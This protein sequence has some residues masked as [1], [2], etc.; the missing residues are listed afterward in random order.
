MTSI[1]TTFANLIKAWGNLP[2][3]Y[4]NYVSLFVITF[5]IGVISIF[6]PALQVLYGIVFFAISVVTVFNP[7]DFTETPEHSTVNHFDHASRYNWWTYSMA[8]FVAVATLLFVFLPINQS[9]TVLVCWI[10]ACL[11]LLSYMP[12]IELRLAIGLLQDY[13]CRQFPEIDPFLIRLFIQ[14]QLFGAKV[15]LSDLNENQLSKLKTMYDKYVGNN[16]LKEN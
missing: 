2:D 12:L 16:G 6:V 15:D 8:G 3:A 14:A 5:P 13:L 11:I 10:L 4:R 1:K 9:L 7:K